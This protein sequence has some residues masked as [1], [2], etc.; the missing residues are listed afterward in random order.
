[1]TAPFFRRRIR[2]TPIVATLIVTIVAIL[3]RWPVFGNPVVQ[4]DEEFY[5]LV[6]DRLL[7]GAIP[8]VDIWDRKPIG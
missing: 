7:H 4:I 5:L 2:I 3:A 1:M 6:G 8:Y